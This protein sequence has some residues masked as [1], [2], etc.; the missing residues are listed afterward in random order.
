MPVNWY[1]LS[2]Q[3]AFSNICTVCIHGRVIPILT[4]CILYIYWY[5]SIAGKFGRGKFGGNFTLVSV[6]KEGLGNG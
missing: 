4:S 5:R 2:G 3:S 1:S 6:N